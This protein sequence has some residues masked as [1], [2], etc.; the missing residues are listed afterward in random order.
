M[1]KILALSISFLVFAISSSAQS[2][3][4][5]RN[6]SNKYTN[7]LAIDKITQDSNRNIIF[8]SNSSV[9]I[10]NSYSWKYLALNEKISALLTAPQGYALAITPKHIYKILRD[11]LLKIKTFPSPLDSFN[12]AFVIGKKVFITSKNSVLI[13]HKNKLSKFSPKFNYLSAL[14][15]HGKL[16]FLIKG[17]GLAD[18]SGNLLISSSDSIKPQFFDYTNDQLVFAYQPDNI[19]LVQNYSCYKL[20]LDA[21]PYLKK[22]LINSIKFVN[23]SIIAISTQSGGIILYNLNKNKTIDIINNLTGLP[24]NEITSLF[25]DDN[26]NL[27]CVH[28]FGISFIDLSL[29]LKNIGRYAGLQGK[30]TFITKYH[31]QYLVGT[32]NGLFTLQKPSNSE[33]LKLIKIKSS[34]SSDTISASKQIIPKPQKGFFRRFLSLFSFHKKNK[35]TSKSAQ[36]A[37]STP[38]IKYVTKKILSDS[39]LAFQNKFTLF[40]KKIKQINSK[41]NKIILFNN[42]PLI[43]TTNKIISWPD[44]KIL[45]KANFIVDADAQ[46]FI[47]VLDDKG[48]AILRPPSYK[49]FYIINFSNNNLKFLSLALQGNTIWL[50]TYG[51]ASEITLDNNLHIINKKTFSI[52]PLALSPVKIFNINNSIILFSNNRIFK[53]IKDTILPLKNIPQFTWINNQTH[54]AIWYHA[55]QWKTLYNNLTSADLTALINALP[56]INNIFTLKDSTFIYNSKN[57]IIIV[58]NHYKL[59]KLK[60]KLHIKISVNQP[61]IKYKDLQKLKL[62]FLSPFYYAP[63]KSTYLLGIK[64]K[65]ENS[66]NWIKL[67]DKNYLSPILQPGHYTLIF[68][69]INPFKQKS[70]SFKTH[71]FIKPPFTQTI[72]FYLLIIFSTILIISLFFIIRQKQLKKQNQILEQLVKQRT[73]EIEKQK[74]QLRKQRD[75]IAMQHQLLKERNEEIIAQ[76]EQIQKQLEQIS[77]L[78]EEIESSIRYAQRIQYAILSK[79]SILSN[80]FKEYF[81]IYLPKHVV[82]GDFYWVKQFNSTI[83]V[84]VADCTGHGVPGAFL[85]ILGYA[86]LNEIVSSFNTSDPAFILNKLREKI[87]Q[88]LHEKDSDQALSDGMDIALIAFNKQTKIITFAG[89]Y[90]PAYIVRQDQLI[91]LKAQ[92]MPVGKYPFPN[93]KITEFKNQTFQTIPNDMIYLFSDGFQDQFN[94]N[95]KKFTK[96]NFKKLL[97]HVA[98]VS[99]FEQKNLILEA[100]KQ[101]KADNFQTDDITIL[102]LRV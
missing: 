64:K 30:I 6:F 88:T 56:N 99:A 1:K 8:A 48:I 92:R 5:I 22:H 60:F 36:P 19:F 51:L 101:W 29:N 49:P 16:L 10:F 96:T 35:T 58:S 17:F 98:D 7:A 84:A 23:D 68:Q 89:A 82:S 97:I 73:A 41:V 102:G 52:D 61:Y 46:N 93:A 39:A 59:P 37:N 44:K 65:Y 3:G 24:D 21:K 80:Y 86:F 13:L 43:I 53:A 67:K 90:N 50:G 76:K 26:H 32:T 54:N 38:K 33:L 28:S 75:E 70:N 95:L 34:A 12:N 20:D 31:K 78:H 91:E 94:P 77:K 81:I 72:G 74:E 11:T 83:L 27:W 79:I 40:F 87:I 63:N 55:N 69:A 9:L 2:V 14:P 57:Q 66:V 4:I 42:K 45:F 47:A 85:T 71:F 15:Y 18:S 100:F 25:V 62:F